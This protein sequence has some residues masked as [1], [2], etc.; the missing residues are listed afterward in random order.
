MKVGLIS[1][2]RDPQDQ[3]LRTMSC[4]LKREGYDVRMI[5]IPSA[6]LESKEDFDQLAAVC[7]G[8]D[9]VGISS[10]T[11]ATIKTVRIIKFL[12]KIVPNVLWGGVHATL[13]PEYCIKYCDIV[14]VGEGEGATLDLAEA[15][16]ENKPI[17]NIQ[18]L[19]IRKGDEIIKNPIR[20][21]IHDVDNIPF[22]DYDIE[23]HFIFRDGKLRRYKEEDFAGQIIFMSGRGCPYGCDFC[24]ND[25]FNEMYKDKRKG[26]LRW[27]SVDY[28]IEGF[29]NL[30]NK[31]PTIKFFEIS[32]DAFFYRPLRQIQEFS[33][34]YKKHIGIPFKCT[35]DPKTVNEEKIKLL[36]EAGCYM[37]TIGIQSTER[38]NQEVYHRDMTDDNVI[39]CAKIFNQFKDKVS[40]SYD[41]ITC[42]PYE[43]SEDLVN[44]VRLLQNLPR[45]YRLCVSSLVYFPETAIAKRALKDGYVTEEELV[46]NLDYV[47]RVT[48]LLRR[49]ENLY[50]NLILTMM[51]GVAVGNKI[52]LLTDERIN[53]L[54]EEERLKRNLKDPSA[55]IRFI[56][57][58]ALHDFLKYDIL[59]QKIFNRLPGV[60]KELYMEARYKN[61]I[62]YETGR[63]I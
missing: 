52:G 16:K 63:N 41:I 17:D 6:E 26:I 9:L 11:V 12:R 24:S 21:Q 29:S 25:V 18:N 19:W 7:K 43:T 8:L 15:I 50:L 34:K 60:F 44:L 38:V 27:H 4:L 35:T 3:G 33:E 47:D 59:K 36:I 49:K 10:M 62:S 28:I 56:K 54:L 51:R 45:P 23:N 37:F 2:M 14:C 57:F 30:K 61:K 58:L 31:F 20:H 46:S 39:K 53:Y 32:D 55:S 13:F 5:F 40:V 48:H 42:N 1:T 22:P